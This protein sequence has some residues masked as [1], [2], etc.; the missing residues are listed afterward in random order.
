MHMLHYCGGLIVRMCDLKHCPMVQ[1]H[2]ACTNKAPQT[3]PELLVHCLGMEQLAGPKQ[4]V[5]G[6]REKGSGRKEAATG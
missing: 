2:C 6:F 3:P 5:L 4:I 1:V